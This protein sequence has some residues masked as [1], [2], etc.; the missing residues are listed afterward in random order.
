[1]ANRIMRE[2][3]PADW[4]LICSMEIGTSLE[5]L[6]Y[7]RGDSN[8]T[9]EDVPLTKIELRKITDGNFSSSDWVEYNAQFYPVMLN[10]LCYYIL[11]SRTTWLI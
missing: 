7:G 10:L 6:T 4:I 11:R 5:W 9:N 3:F 1:M 8:I 2:N